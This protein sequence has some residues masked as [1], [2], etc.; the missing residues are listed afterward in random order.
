MALLSGSRLLSFVSYSV[1][2][3]SPP[4]CAAKYEYVFHHFDLPTCPRREFFLPTSVTQLPYELTPGQPHSWST[5]TPSLCPGFK[6]YNL[7]QSGDQGPALPEEQAINVRI[8]RGSSCSLDVGYIYAPSLQRS[9]RFAR[10]A[11]IVANL[12]MQ[13]SGVSPSDT[14]VKTERLATTKDLRRWCARTAMEAASPCV[15]S[16][17]ATIPRTVGPSSAF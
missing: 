14:A 2:L 13:G 12:V 15:G 4:D 7:R 1:L 6:V 5:P 10:S 3:T 8:N 11:T 17:L 16:H 9:E